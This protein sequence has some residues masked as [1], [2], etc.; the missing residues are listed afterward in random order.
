MCFFMASCFGYLKDLAASN[1]KH[2]TQEHLKMQM[3][4]TFVV[5]IQSYSPE[6]LEVFISN[7]LEW[8]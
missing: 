7:G 4:S 2:W 6:C 5:V 3:M 1:R 8:C